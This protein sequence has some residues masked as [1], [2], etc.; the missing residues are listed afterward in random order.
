MIL[1]NVPLNYGKLHKWSLQVRADKG[2]RCAMCG[3]EPDGTFW[4]RIEAHHIESKEERPDLIYDTK[5][6]IPLCRTCHT[7]VHGGQFFLEHESHPGRIDSLKAFYQ[8][9]KEILI[10]IM[11]KNG[12][13]HPA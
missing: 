3:C 12:W 11:E 1:V 9:K 4:K 5:N 7:S 10:G 8:Q 6:G 13:E 2:N